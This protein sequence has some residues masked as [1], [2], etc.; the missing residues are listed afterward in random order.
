MSKKRAKCLQT[1]A[2][3]PTYFVPGY[4]ERKQAPRCVL[5]MLTRNRVDSRVAGR[6]LSTLL[7][8]CYRALQFFRRITRW[9]A[10]SWWRKEPG[11]FCSLERSASRRS[12]SRGQ[13]SSCRRGNEVAG[14][15]TLCSRG[16]TRCCFCYTL[17]LTG[18]S[19]PAAHPGYLAV[20][21]FRALQ[22]LQFSV[23]CFLISF[24]L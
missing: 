14:S 7:D 20:P 12:S 10:V 19:P 6:N 13:R 21:L 5:R 17:F 1:H 8:L 23:P 2:S 9:R 18:I 4:T 3:H 16:P 24:S 11:C 22:Y 15:T